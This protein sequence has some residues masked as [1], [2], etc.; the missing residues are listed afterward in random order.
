MNKT[1]KYEMMREKK[2]KQQVLSNLTGKI[3]LFLWPSGP[4]METWVELLR[5]L[6]ADAQKPF[7]SLW[8]ILSSAAASVH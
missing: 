4:N 7:W 8:L 1:E 2:R 5:L 3:V 6:L